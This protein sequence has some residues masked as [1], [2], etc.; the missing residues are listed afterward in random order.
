MLTCFPWSH[1]CICKLGLCT[2]IPYY[3]SFGLLRRAPFLQIYT[4]P[5]SE[6]RWA[7]LFFNR[8]ETPV[9]MST[10]YTTMGIT[11]D[12]YNV[13][14]LWA[15]A[16]VPSESMYTLETGEIPPHGVKFYTLKARF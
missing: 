13:R 6:D 15:Q 7:V 4:A 9:S 16:D 11:E 8:G 1:L 2:A 10:N 3:S 12:L 5:L 14:D